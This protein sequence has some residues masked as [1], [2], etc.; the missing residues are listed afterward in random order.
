M[1]A[2]A[3]PMSAAHM[4][5]YEALYQ[6]LA[7]TFPEPRLI[8]DPLRKLAY[9]TDA[10]FYRLV[11]QLVVIVEDEAEVGRLLAA[12]R[13]YGT[14]VTFRAAGTS[15]SGQAVTDSV[16]AMLGDGWGGIDIAADAATIRLQPACSAVTPTAGSPASAARSGPTRRRSTPARSAAS[17]PT[18]PAA[19]AAARRRTAITRS[20]A[21]GSCW[22]T[23]RCSTRGMRRAA[24]LS[25]G[26]MARCSSDCATWANAP[27][28]MPTL[29]ARIRRKFAIKNTTGYSLN[30]L[31]DFSDPF[32]I[33]EHL[34][35]GSE[36]TLGFISEI[37]Y[38]TVPEYADKA[39]ALMLFPS[40]V[41]ACAAIIRLKPAPVAAVELMD[42][43]SL[44]SVEDKPGMPEFIRGLPDGATALLV[45]TRAESRDCLRPTSTRSAQ[46]WPIC[47]PCCRPPSPMFPPSTSKL[48]N[49]R[50][51]MFPSVGAMRETGTTVIIEDV[52]FPIESLAAA[53]ARPAGAAG[54]ARLPRGDHLRPRARRQSALRLH[55][56]FRQ[57]QR[58]RA[59]SPLHG[60]CLRDGRRQLRRLAQ[61]GARHRPQHGA[62][63]RAGMGRAGL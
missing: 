61:G 51:G 59:L 38:H 1:D 49:I 63:R 60:R 34:M 33:L 26:R 39:S 37:T 52:A 62:V 12:C 31:V 11:P 54:R 15:L 4:P 42:R 19:C 25:R 13:R 8:G 55:P 28:P 2:S 5:N 20:P 57:R 56:G 22:P 53:T 44:R 58:G 3:V 41:D 16:L 48:W 50:K 40:V 9:G 43:A 45:E 7:T 36:G 23:A 32:D 46:P 27:A 30:A 18:T 17:P 47:R 6:E 21:C 29:A 14:P 24:Q 35:I 10:S